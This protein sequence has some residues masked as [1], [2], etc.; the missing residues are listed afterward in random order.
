MRSCLV[1]FIANLDIGQKV[2]I[3]PWF[4]QDFTVARMCTVLLFPSNKIHFTW[5]FRELTFKL[6][7]IHFM[8][9]YFD[10]SI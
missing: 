9:I 7:S 2:Q 4:E 5:R 1:V 3:R 8:N 6:L 10:L